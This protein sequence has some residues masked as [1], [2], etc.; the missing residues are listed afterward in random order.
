MPHPSDLDHKIAVVVDHGS[1]HLVWATQY[2]LVDGIGPL[3]EVA[4]AVSS[5]RTL[6]MRPGYIDFLGY[7]SNLRVTPGMWNTP[8]EHALHESGWELF[9]ATHHLLTEVD[10]W[11]LSESHSWGDYVQFRVVREMCILYQKVNG[12]T[13]LVPGVHVRCAK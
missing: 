13:Y 1:G 10:S 6:D 9:P 7:V 12:R 5:S 3:T 4:D 11:W 8:F 2:P